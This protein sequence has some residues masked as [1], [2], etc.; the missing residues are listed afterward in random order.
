MSFFLY[1][2]ILE[3]KECDSNPCNNDAKCKDLKDDYECICK[4][5]FS[6]RNCDIER[7]ECLSNPCYDNAVCVDKV[8]TSFHLFIKVNLKLI[9]VIFIIKK[10][11]NNVKSEFSNRR[12][13]SQNAQTSFLDK[14]T[15]LSFSP[16]R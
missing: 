13:I 6:G 4:P 9:I 5:G 2:Y 8:E 11:T 16:M 10:L 1:K 14:L 7:S 15:P 3:T 12:K